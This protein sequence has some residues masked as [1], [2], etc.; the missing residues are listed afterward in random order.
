[1]SLY[2]IL[3]GVMERLDCIRRNFLWDGNSDKRK[4]LLM[5]WNDV[6]KVKAL[7]GLGLGCFALKDC[8]LLAKWRWRFRVETE[9]L[10][11]RIF[12]AKFGEG[13]RG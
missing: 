11:R 2:K 1:M 13:Q 10:W 7:S 9:A 3:V 8:A 4:L 6:V 5:K 12:V